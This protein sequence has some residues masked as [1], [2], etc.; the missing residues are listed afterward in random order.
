MKKQIFTLALLLAAFSA[1]AQDSSR[2]LDE[3]VVTATK[4]SQKQSAIGRVT[5]VITAEELRRSEGKTLGEVL[6]NQAGIRINGANGA[7][8]TNQSVFLRGA[9]DGYTLIMIDGVTVYD[10]SQITTH[11]D[12]NLIPLDMI[13]HIEIIRG[14]ASTLYGSGAVAGVINIITKKGGDKPVGGSLAFSGGSYSTF[15]QNAGVYGKTKLLDYHV[16]L[17][18]LDSKGFP[19]AVDT[20]GKGDFKNDGFHEKAVNANFG[21]QVNPSFRIQPFFRYS[22]E[23][24]DLPAGAFIDDPYYTYDTKYLQTGLQTIYSLPG[25]EFH[26]MYSYNTTE[27][28][29]LDDTAAGKSNYYSEKD[30]SRLQVADAYFTFQVSNRV[31]LLTGA[32]YTYSDLNQN[33]LY[34]VPGYTAPGAISDDSTRAILA[35]AYA[36]LFLKN[37]N[38]FNL[39]AG[40]RLNN[41]SVYGFNPTFTFNPFYSFH[42][43]HKIFVTVASTFNAPSLYQLYS[44]YG[45]R[46]LKP[47]KGMSY[48]A[49]FETLVNDRLKLRISGFKRDMKDVIAFGTKYINYNRQNDYGGELEAEYVLNEKITLKGYYTYTKGNVTAQNGGKDTTYNNLFKRAPSTFGASVAW[50]PTPSLFIGSDLKYTGQRNDLRF[51][52]WPQ[53]VTVENLKPYVLWNLQAGYTFGKRLY[54]FADLKN[55]TNSDYVESLGYATRRFNFDAGVR[56]SP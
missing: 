12:L 18:N 15:R 13:D 6:N 20:T 35:S 8:G 52:P 40:G 27:R 45:N 38:G 48:E 16:D 24:G 17:T 2:S 54:V 36:S 30:N 46:F 29:Y 51:N 21:V 25:G 1:F 50:Q 53:P 11:F 5:A 56:V 19:A 42:G 37:E 43:R 23:K 7:P 49:G 55:I 28:N 32:S 33:S 4:S 22:Y 44:P 10:P 9:A 3:V 39:E 14:A 47:E 41:H 34:I 31:E 26:L